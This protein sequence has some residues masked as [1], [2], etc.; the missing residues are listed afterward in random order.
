MAQ[1]QG[2]ID[3]WSQQITA[4]A[5]SDP[6]AWATAADIQTATQTARDIVGQRAAYLQ[7]FVDCE[8]GVAGAA[9]DADGDGYKWCDECDDSNPNVHPGAKEICG[10]GID[11]DCNGFVDDGC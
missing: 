6:H 1:I 2:W 7:T 4:A 5:T 9:T 10:N 11:D 8:H 3:T